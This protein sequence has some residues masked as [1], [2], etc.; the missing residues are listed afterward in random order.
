[1]RPDTE[2][3]RVTAYGRTGSLGNQ[4]GAGSSGTSSL[5]M[6]GRVGSSGIQGGASCSDAQGGSAFV[7]LLWKP[8]SAT[9]AG[10]ESFLGEAMGL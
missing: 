6:Y 7:P 8:V 5:A 4:G 9:M 2:I 1:M 10:D 3:L